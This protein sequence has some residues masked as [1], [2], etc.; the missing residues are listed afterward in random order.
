V[1]LK[2][3]KDDTKQN[4]EPT[5]MSAPTSSPIEDED[6][7]FEYPQ[8]SYS[9]RLNDVLDSEEE[10][11]S[12]SEGSNDAFVYSGQDAPQG[13]YREQLSEVLG[14]E[15]ADLED[16]EEERQVEQH[17]LRDMS[18]SPLPSVTPRVV[19]VQYLDVLTLHNS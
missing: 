10:H 18:A 5:R 13:G 7:T 15:T 16:I 2:E 6:E 3:R 11:D 19:Q 8:E 17:L 4:I 12:A 1:K 9:S 14:S